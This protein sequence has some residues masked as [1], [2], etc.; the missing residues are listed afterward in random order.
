ST[1]DQTDTLTTIAQNTVDV[2]NDTVSL[3]TAALGEGAATTAI[4]KDNAVT[5]AVGASTT[6]RFLVWI[7]NKGA[8]ADTYNLTTTF[9][10]TNVAGVT[11]PALPGGWSVS[12]RS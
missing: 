4:I 5:P 6:S 3:T 7:L 2:T 9:A 10:A 11:P 8:I 1:D 12:F